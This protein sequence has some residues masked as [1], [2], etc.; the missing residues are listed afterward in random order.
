MSL[1]FQV[2]FALLAMGFAGCSRGPAVGEVSGKVTFGEKPVSEGRITFINAAKGYAAEAVLQQDGSYTIA[3][4]EGGLVVGDYI[5]MINPLIVV[6]RSNPHSPPAPVEKSAP[7]IPEK[8]R[9][10]GRT[11]F[12][13]SVQKG[14]NTFNFEMT[15]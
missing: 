7:N 8:Y 2:L 12:R 5:V 14:A 10:Q 1:H 11:P 9:N 13:A 6:D 15:R 4:S 3:T